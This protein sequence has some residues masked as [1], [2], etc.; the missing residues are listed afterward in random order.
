MAKKNLTST[1]IIFG[2]R[3]EHL[4]IST[5]SAEP[6][7]SIEGL[8]YVLEP[9]G[10]DLIVNVKIGEHIIKAIANPGLMLTPGQ[11]IWL[12]IDYDK[13]HIFDKKTEKAII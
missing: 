3:P 6:D 13:I 5:T 10:R 7:R 9:L 4:V 8:V 1:E 12:V 2:I 11:K